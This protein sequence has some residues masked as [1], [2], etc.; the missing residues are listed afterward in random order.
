MISEDLGGRFC[1][2]LSIDHLYANI[3]YGMMNRLRYLVFSFDV[4]VLFSLPSDVGVSPLPGL[5]P[6]VGRSLHLA[7][8]TTGPL[9]C[10]ERVGLVLWGH[11]GRQ[12]DQPVVLVGCRTKPGRSA[13]VAGSDRQPDSITR[14]AQ[15]LPSGRQERDT[16]HKSFDRHPPSCKSPRASPDH[17]MSNACGQQW[18]PNHADDDTAPVSSVAPSSEEG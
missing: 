14:G 11:C 12:W 4:R 8:D 15:P 6:C 7:G 5:W 10:I 2:F 3:E 13:G 18:F 16:E 1:A 17:T 9:V